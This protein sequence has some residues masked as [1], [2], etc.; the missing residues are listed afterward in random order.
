MLD[1]R[2]VDIPDFSGVGKLPALRV[3]RMGGQDTIE[4]LEPLSGLVGLKEIHLEACPNFRS[5]KGIPPSVSQYAGFTHC[6]KLESIAGIEACEG[7]EQ[8][9]VTGCRNLKSIDEVAKLTSLV[10]LSLVKCREVTDITPVV[11]L[12]KLTIVM[13]GGSGVLPDSVEDLETANPDII[14][15]FAVGE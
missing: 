15:D 12:E 14:F 8:L 10:Q 5:L 2:N 6:P 4:T 3:L 9:D 13:L 7:L 11:A 1:I